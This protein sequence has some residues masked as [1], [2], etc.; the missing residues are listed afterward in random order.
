[1][2]RKTK[3]GVISGITLGFL[4]VAGVVVILILLLRYPGTLK[5]SGGG[6]GSIG[7]MGPVGPT[8]P[9]GPKGDTGANGKIGATGS[10]VVSKDDGGNVITVKGD[11]GETGATGPAGAQGMDGKDGK[12]GDN[13]EAGATGPQGLP[14]S[15]GI[16]GK[17][18]NDGGIGETGATGPQGAQGT[19]SGGDG[20]QYITWDSAGNATFAGSIIVPS[21]TVSGN[22]NIGGALTT[23]GNITTSKGNIVATTGTLQRKPVYDSGWKA[24]VKLNAMIGVPLPSP[25]DTQNPYTIQVLASQVGDG[26][27][28]SGNYVVDITNQFTD[29]SNLGGWVQTGYTA[30]YLSSTSLQLTFGSKNIYELGTGQTFQTAYIRVLLY[31]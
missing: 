2:D 30:V 5:L 4:G 20:T 27:F 21:L 6:K 10:V 18:G 25:L 22:T 7:P 12:D 11:T 26:S 29:T 15:P 19:D 16:D 23:Q 13:G 8:G 3:I 9:V 17:N 14:G 1:M 28:T 31:K 24:N